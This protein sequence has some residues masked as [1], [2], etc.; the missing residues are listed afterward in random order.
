MFFLWV[1]WKR[2]LASQLGLSRAGKIIRSA[3]ARYSDYRLHQARPDHPALK[4][5]LNL[6]IF[7]TCFYQATL[8]RSGAAELTPLFCKMD[9]LFYDDVSPYLRF[10]RL[11]TLVLTGQPC[12]FRFYRTKLE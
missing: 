10:E 6:F 4:R 8:N 2:Q 1:S 9:R 5:H 12:D 11:N 3:R 7:H